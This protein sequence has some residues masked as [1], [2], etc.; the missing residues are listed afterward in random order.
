MVN[1]L[2]DLRIYRISTKYSVNRVIAKDEV[3]WQSHID[4]DIMN[5]NRRLLRIV[6]AKNSSSQ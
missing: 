3:L 5:D 1:R 6:G 2:E 4:S